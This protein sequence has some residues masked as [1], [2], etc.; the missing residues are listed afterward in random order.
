M[1]EQTMELEAILQKLRD[2]TPGLSTVALVSSDGLVISSTIKD[3]LESE[4]IAA[5]SAALHSQGETSAIDARLGTMSQ[6]IMKSKDGYI[7]ITQSGKD[8]L[9][10]VFANKT[11][12]LG[13]VL[14]EI[15]CSLQDIQNHVS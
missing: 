7:V 10:T 1:G 15:E 6:I 8:T 4:K 13:L 9:L 12:K 2:D 14:F 3:N 5:I 11:A